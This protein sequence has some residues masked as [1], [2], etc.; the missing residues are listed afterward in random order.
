MLTGS[1][2]FSSWETTE[3]NLNYFIYTGNSVNGDI[4]G[5]ITTTEPI[6]T[7]G[8]LGET[9]CWRWNIILENKQSTENYARY[10]SQNLN[11]T[12]FDGEKINITSRSSFCHAF[13]RRLNSLLIKCEVF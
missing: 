8:D 10:L 12:V 3:F 6:I 4:T 1:V 5:E 11:S 9:G 13:T 2:L 7:Y